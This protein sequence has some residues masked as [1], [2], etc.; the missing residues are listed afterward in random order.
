MRY[1]RLLFL[2]VLALCLVVVAMANR[3]T[4][5]LTLLPEELAAFADFQQTVDLPLY[6][7][8]FLGVLVGLLI[9][10]VWEWIREGKQRAQAARNRREAAKMQRE[11]DRMK[12]E[13]HKD[14]GRDEIL[15]LVEA[16]GKTG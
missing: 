12:A 6:G 7:V 2:L 1:I 16:G 5:T 13:K 9:G 3:E 10:F 14:E 8:G 11:L 4:V 15:A